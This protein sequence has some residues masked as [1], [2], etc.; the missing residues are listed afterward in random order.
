MLAAATLYRGI[1]YVLPANGSADQL[2]TARLE[3]PPDGPLA[4]TIGRSVGS[5]SAAHQA[6]LLKATARGWFPRL[7]P[8]NVELHALGRR[9]DVGALAQAV[10]GQVI[11]R[12]DEAVDHTSVIVCGLGKV[13]YRVVTELSGAASQPEVIALD[14][15]G[16]NDN[17]Q[18]LRRH[19]AR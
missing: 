1:E 2:A 15:N 8:A 12:G 5:P 6:R 19:A 4:S 13:G 10:C 3:P 16:L 11:P 18:D 14:K 17:E 9:A 7:T